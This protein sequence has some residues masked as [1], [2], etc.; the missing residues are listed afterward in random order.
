MIDPS[1]WVHEHTGAND[2]PYDVAK[3]TAERVANGFSTYDWWNTN[4][5][6][7]FVIIGMLKKFKSDGCGFPGHMTSDE[8]NTTLDV[9]IEGFEAA[10]EIVN[11]EY[12]LASFDGLELTRKRGMDLFVENYLTLWD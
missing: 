6:L 11:G 7:N 2:E 1:L 10:E 5:Y 8:W 3:H 12:S 9:M 4:S